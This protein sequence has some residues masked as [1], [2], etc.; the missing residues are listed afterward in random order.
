[1]HSWADIENRF[2]A[3]E[4]PLRGLRLDFQWGDAGKHWNLTGVQR[5][6]GYRECLLLSGVAGKLLEHS[7]M[8]ERDPGRWLL[9]EQNQTHR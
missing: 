5:E 2:R 3:L 1:M 8:A 6:E 7:L 9:Q 4:E